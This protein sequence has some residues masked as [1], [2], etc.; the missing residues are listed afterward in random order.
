MDLPRPF[1]FDDDTTRFVFWKTEVLC[2]AECISSRITKPEAL[3]TLLTCT[4]ETSQSRA[5]LT[6]LIKST[7]TAGKRKDEFTACS[8]PLEI[9]EWGLDYLSLYFSDPTLEIAALGKMCEPQGERSISQYLKDVTLSHVYTDSTYEEMERYVGVQVNA[10]IQA[11]MA[12][13]LRKD[14]SEF[15]FEDFCQTGPAAEERIM[16]EKRLE[17]GEEIERGIRRSKTPRIGDW[18]SDEDFVGR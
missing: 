11:R 18:S 7:R 6:A 4:H 12:Q 16:R 5:L 2:Y 1:T 13:I 17:K 10:D 15:T 8:S 9:F 14:A 3:Y